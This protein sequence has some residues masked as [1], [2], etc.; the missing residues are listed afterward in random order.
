M[1]LRNSVLICALLIFESKSRSTCEPFEI[2]TCLSVVTAAA[3]SESSRD[4]NAPY[5][6]MNLIESFIFAFLGRRSSVLLDSNFTIRLLQ[7]FDA[8]D[9]RNDIGQADAEFFVHHN[10]F[11]ARDE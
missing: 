4:R 9:R 3:L 1:S 10:H 2:C 5:T 7:L 6:D 11:A 8:L